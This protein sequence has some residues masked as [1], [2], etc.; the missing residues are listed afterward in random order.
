MALK[1]L[2]KN[3]R[4]YQSASGPKTETIMIYGEEVETLG[5]SE[6][7]RTKA[8]FRGDIGWVN[9]RDLTDFDKAESDDLLTDMLSL[10]KDRILYLKN[11][12][13]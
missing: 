3:S 13:E 8:R 1:Y 10:L 2:V 9:D 5:V 11:I 6:N 12:F 7:N 4:L